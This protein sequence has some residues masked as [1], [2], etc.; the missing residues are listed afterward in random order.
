M[1]RSKAAIDSLEEAE[2]IL[3]ALAQAV[4]H[5]DTYTAG[6]CERLAQDSVLLGMTLGLGRRDLLALHRGGFLHDIGKIAVPDAI[7]HKKGS[8]TEEEWIVMRSHT[9]K[10]EDICRPMKTL[11]SVLPIIRSHHERWDGSGYPDGLRGQEI[12]LVA[13]V[14]QIAD[15]YDALTTVRPYKPAFTPAASLRI[16]E[17]ESAKGWWDPK[18][19]E[20][21]C[22]LQRQGQIPLAGESAATWPQLERLSQSIT[23]AD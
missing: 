17:E 5:R 19:V 15:I 8:L 4:E 13:R 16:L 21:F 11:Q 10:G 7:L 22:R 18:L 3:F 9:F 2:S 23:T 20:V 14:L 6:H 12:P 1:L